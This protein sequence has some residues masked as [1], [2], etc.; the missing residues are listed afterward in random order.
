MSASDVMARAGAVSVPGPWRRILARVRGPLR[1]LAGVLLSL[2]PL[3]AIIVLGWLTRLMRD[4][5]RVRQGLLRTGGTDAAG[6]LPRRAALPSWIAGEIDARSLPY[7]WLGGLLANLRLGVATLATAAVGTLPFS[8]LWL[9][10][11]WAGWENSFNKGY[12]QA[13]IGPVLWGAGVLIALPL[14]ARLPMALA[15]QAETGRFGAVFEVRQVRALIAAAGWRYVLL[16]LLSVLAVLPILLFRMMPVFVE[17]WLPGFADM[18]EAEVATVARRLHVVAGVYVFLAVLLL[19]R[20]AARVHAL[21]VVRLQ[22]DGGP[23]GGFIRTALRTVVLW[24]IW[25][26]LPVQILI[27]QFFNHHWWLWVTHPVTA[28]PWLP[29]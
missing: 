4:E 26:V 14:L 19:R 6:D 29:G 24:L 9:L 10:A 23:P 7:R 5:S 18:D 1:L 13:W 11:W 21:A 2:N 28:L 17:A 25:L 20:S 15:H 3:T 22:H 8:L 16:A 27:G 12:E